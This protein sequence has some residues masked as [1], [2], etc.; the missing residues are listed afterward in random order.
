[1]SSTVLD[2]Y[3]RTLQELYNATLNLLI[4]LERRELVE[5]L[6]I[7][8][9]SQPLIERAE[10]LL[11]EVSQ[12]SSG[13]SEKERKS[14]EDAISLHYR[15]E[16]LSQQ[17]QQMIKSYMQELKEKMSQLH[18][19]RKLVESQRDVPAHIVHI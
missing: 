6:E 1:M 10:A 4:R 8:R 5:A 17:C 16:L 9:S 18:G 11:D 15:I 12:R 7:Q 2:E 14:V 19:V 3:Y 13:L